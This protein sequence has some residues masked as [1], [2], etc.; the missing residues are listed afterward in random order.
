MLDRIL[1]EDRGDG[2]RDQADDVGAEGKAPVGEVQGG[3]NTGILALAMRKTLE[4]CKA[5]KRRLRHTK[6]SRRDQ[7]TYT[8]DNRTAARQRRP[9]RNP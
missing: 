5:D 6:S 9:S 1:T 8:S 2:G 3:Q 4:H 7:R